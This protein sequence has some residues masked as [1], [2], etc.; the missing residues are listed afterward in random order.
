MPQLVLDPDDRTVVGSIQVDYPL[1]VSVRSF[2]R[3]P[4]AG[5]LLPGDLLL[6]RAK[7]ADFVGRRIE[8]AQRRGGFSADDSRWTH[9][10]VYVGDHAL[11]EARPFRGVGYSNFYSYIGGHYIRAR[12]DPS[13]TTDQRYR[14]AIEA[15]TRLRRSYSILRIAWLARQSFVGYWSPVAPVVVAQRLVCSQ[16]YADAYLAVTKTLVANTQTAIFTPAHLSA[17]ARLQDIPLGWV[18]IA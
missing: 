15:L 6:F 10:A 7:N 13:L 5:A 1:P 14:L 17:T 4:D 9:A 11:C 18:D 2:G 16:L 12:R 8:G 3:L